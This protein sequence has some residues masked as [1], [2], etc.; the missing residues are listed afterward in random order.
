MRKFLLLFFCAFS[1]SMLADTYKILFVNTEYITI[2]G[3]QLKA[4]DSFEDTDLITWSSDKQ[5]FKAQNIKSKKIKLFVSV[6]MK[7]SKSVA[8]YYLKSNILSTRGN[9][10][11]EHLDD[12]L[13]DSCYYLLDSVK[14]KTWIKSTPN[15]YFMLRYNINGQDYNVKLSGEAEYITLNSDL[16]GRDTEKNEPSEIE[17]VFWYHFSNDEEEEIGNMKIVFV[18]EAINE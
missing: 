8:D 15:D 5:A 12:I 9:E 13:S 10:R 7:D 16:P 18:D 17:V 14:L 2:G 6:Q 11:Y 3:K 4:G 1:L